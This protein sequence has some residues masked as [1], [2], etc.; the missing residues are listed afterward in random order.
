[1]RIYLKKKQSMI[2][3]FECAWHGY[4]HGT[5]LIPTLQFNNIGKYGWT[6]DLNWLKL[7]VTFGYIKKR[8][9]YADKTRE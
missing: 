4:W 7:Y 6:L 5:Y 8:T 2:V 3:L 9:D 1:M